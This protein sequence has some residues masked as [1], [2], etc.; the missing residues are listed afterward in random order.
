ML[1][2]DHEQAM[3]VDLTRPEFNPSLPERPMETLFTTDIDSLASRPELGNQF[4]LS[5]EAQLRTRQK[6]R[7]QKKLKNPIDYTSIKKEEWLAPV[8]DN[9]R[10]PFAPLPDR[11]VALKKV[12]LRIWCEEAAANKCISTKLDL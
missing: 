8:V 3:K 5:T 2:Y 10:A 1:S 6:V 11:L 9:T 4:L 12:T 7:W